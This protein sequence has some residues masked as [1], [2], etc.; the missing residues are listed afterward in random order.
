MC[1][2][3]NCGEYSSKWHV[4][5]KH[6]HSRFRDLCGRV[7]GGGWFQRTHFSVA[8]GLVHIGIYKGCDSMH[9]HCTSS[10]QRKIR[11][12]RRRHRWKVPC[13]TKKLFQVMG[14]EYGKFNFLQWCVIGYITKTSRE[15]P[16]TEAT[17]QHKMNFMGFCC[18]YLC[19]VF[20]FWFW[21]FLFYWLFTF[22][23]FCFEKERER[24]N[25]YLGLLGSG[26]DLGRWGM[27]NRAIL[28]KYSVWKI[29]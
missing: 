15:T 23:G 29:K 9:K 26:E 2:M 22:V 13:L 11:T 28:S 25:M 7:R 21:Y 4:S 6:L 19:V 5:I 3:W 24:K 20:Y 14:L 8:I 27:W 18:Y 16:C 10:N 1:S 12:L 17:G